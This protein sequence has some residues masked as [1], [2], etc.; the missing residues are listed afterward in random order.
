[1][2]RRVGLEFVSFPMDPTASSLINNPRR[3]LRYSSTARSED[4]SASWSPFEWRLPY[5]RVLV[6]TAIG[7]A[8]HLVLAI[9][10]LLTISNITF[11]S[12][13][14]LWP[15]IFA[16]AV[17]AYDILC[18]VVAAG[19]KVFQDVWESL[20]PEPIEIRLSE[21]ERRRRIRG[22]VLGLGD[23]KLLLCVTFPMGFMSAISLVWYLTVI[24][25]T[26]PLNPTV[27]FVNYVTLQ[28]FL[29]SFILISLVYA[30]AAFIHHLSTYSQVAYY[31]APTADAEE[32]EPMVT[33]NTRFQRTNRGSNQNTTNNYY[34]NLPANEM[35]YDVD[36]NPI[37]PSSYF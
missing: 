6:T 34:K 14:S 19:S 33:K 3:D 17:A 26:L 5:I 35:E 9:I 30:P 4:P 8:G 10:L 37:E 21:P 28:L 2:S 20:G 36:G 23:L 24:N 16:W 25:M 15:F 7:G 1:M 29:M 32:M 27:D 12:S 11:D 13:I 22:S 31:I 18:C